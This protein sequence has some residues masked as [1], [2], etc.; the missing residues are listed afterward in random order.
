M[1]TPIGHYESAP[2]IF[3]SDPDISSDISD[4]DISVTP[5]FPRYLT[6]NLYA[7]APV[8]WA[9]V[10]MTDHKDTNTL[11]CG[12]IDDGVGKAPERVGA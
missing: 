3:E 11:A 1:N 10:L 7:A 4:P 8:V 5:I 2:D 6:W 9:S 12:A